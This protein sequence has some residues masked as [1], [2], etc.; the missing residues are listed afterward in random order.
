VHESDIMKW[1]RG[2]QRCSMGTKIVNSVQEK[3]QYSPNT[4]DRSLCCF[5]FIFSGGISFVFFCLHI[6]N[7]FYSYFY[8]VI[9]KL[10][11]KTCQKK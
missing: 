3:R 2:C 11:P 7:L 5:N 10:L 9:M 4:I 1:L 6:W 8:Y